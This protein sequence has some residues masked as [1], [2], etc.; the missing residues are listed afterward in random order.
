[1]ADATNVF[2]GV[3]LRCEA[4]NSEHHT[5]VISKNE[6]I[7]RRGQ[8]FTL[9]LTLTKPFN[10]DQHPLVI[11][12]KTGRR[13]SE[14]QGTASLFGIPDAERSPKAKAVWKAELHKDSTP[15]KGNLML[16]I[17]PPADCPIGEYIL[18]VKHMN[19]EM[20]LAKVVVLFNPWCPDDSVYM[21][22][23]AEIH[24][25]VMNEHGSIY[26]GSINYIMS[27][28]WDYGQFEDD[29]VP[30]CLRIL[31]LNSEHKKNPSADVSA[32]SDPTYVGRVVSAMVNSS[33]DDSGVLFG[34]WDGEYRGG[35]NP[36]Y[37][38]GSYA[39]LRRWYNS[40]SNPVMY[41]QCWVFAGVMCSVMRLLGIPTRVVTNFNSAHDT[42]GNMLIDKYHYENK[43]SV[44]YDMIWNFHVWVESWMKRPDLSKEGRFDGWQ[45]LD[46]TPQEKSKGMFRCGPASVK[47]ILEKQTDLKY[48]MS[49]VYAEVN[50]DC[51]DWLIRPGL[52]TLKLST[53]SQTVGQHISTKAVGFDMRV[54]ITDTYKRD[55]VALRNAITRDYC[56]DGRNVTTLANAE[57]EEIGEM[58]EVKHTIET[59]EVIGGTE[60]EGTEEAGEEKEIEDDTECRGMAVN[61]AVRVAAGTIPPSPPVTMQFLEVTPPISGK[62]VQLRLLLRSRVVRNLSVHISVQARRYNGSSSV[63]IQREEK[64]RTLNLGKAL[65]IPIRIPFSTYFEH[66][67]LYDSMEVLVMAM[68]KENPDDVYLAHNNVVLLD[69]SISVKVTSRTKVGRRAAGE[70]VFVN[71]INIPLTEC[72]LTLSGGGLFKEEV[73]IKLPDLQPKTRIRAKFP[74]VPYK[75]GMRILVATFHCSSLKIM[76]S[77]CHVIVEP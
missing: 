36:S 74:F 11:S 56:R 9:S 59:E 67:R 68:D 25:Y 72:K 21:K 34:C 39:I 10:Q 41:G 58:E 2:K 54:D 70:L 55:K 77:S 61:T 45:V 46:A 66:M 13:P 38:S 24:E 44:S 75:A 48:D 12:A 40:G 7:V 42:D 50:A 62:D 18:K 16:T 69:P 17:T 35:V 73:D 19:E 4:N 64:E 33:D 47:A 65:S 14:E 27:A 71:P 6:L 63:V 30:I 53:D 37:W 20:S 76:K 57:M 51:V 43:P 1:M 15:Q 32:R 22:D 5:S 26:K 49:F 29:M 31:D 8:P 3:D 60:D 23:A 52:P 28:I